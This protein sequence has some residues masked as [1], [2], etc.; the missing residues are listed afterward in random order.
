MSAAKVSDSALK[1]KGQLLKVL[2]HYVCWNI[3]CVKRYLVT[4]PVTNVFMG[5][6]YP[7]TQLYRS[8]TSSVPLH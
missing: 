3:K 4:N 2:H 7:G 1:Q 6:L 5:E 8:V